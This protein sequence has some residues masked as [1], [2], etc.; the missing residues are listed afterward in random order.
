MT[1]DPPTT[2]ERKVQ[3]AINRLWY[4]HYTKELTTEERNR[5]TGSFARKHLNPSKIKIDKPFVV[6]PMTRKKI[7]QRTCTVQEVLADFILRDNQSEENPF[8]H[9]EKTV[10][11]AAIRKKR[12]RSIILQSEYDKAIA[13]AK[14]ARK[15]YRKPPYSIEEY[16]FNTESPIERQL[17]AG[18]P[19]SVKGFRRQIEHVKKNAKR[20]AL[21]YERMGYDYSETLQRIRRLDPNRVR[22]CGNAF[23]AHDGRRYV[24]DLQHGINERT[25]ERSQRSACELNYDK[26]KSVNARNY[27]GEFDDLTD[28]KAII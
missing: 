6:H 18:T 26:Q 15:S 27:S 12:E 17:A 2:A 8:H 3:R 23:Y 10:R 1:Y 9:Q 13:E 25:K 14:E 20:Y 11:S 7:K 5:M 24:C 21:K 22:E 16:Q 28:V 4:R 19:Q